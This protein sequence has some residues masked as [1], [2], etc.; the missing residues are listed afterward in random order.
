MNSPS[1]IIVAV[2]EFPPARPNLIARTSCPVP[3]T[4]R[5][6]GHAIDLW[7]QRG[8]GSTRLGSAV[9]CSDA[10]PATGVWRGT[11]AGGGAGGQGGT[12][13]RF[14]GP[15]QVLGTSWLGLSEF[16]LSIS[17]R[18]SAVERRRKTFY[19]SSFSKKV[20]DGFFPTL[21][22]IPSNARDIFIGGLL[23][24]VS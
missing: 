19:N 17:L 13:L 18:G 16:G 5:V 11:V 7:L 10:M 4:A 21:F 24:Q 3:R 6:P 23:F 20:K 15:G 1:V 12:S 14:R 22:I 2:F 8:S 9:C